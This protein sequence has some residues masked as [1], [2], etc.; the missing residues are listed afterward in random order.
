[1]SAP[2]RLGEWRPIATAPKDGSWFATWSPLDDGSE[3]N[4]DKAQWDE[5]EGCFLKVCC[6]WPYVTHWAPFLPGKP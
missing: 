1:M 2:P 4:L 6:G 5:Q 3:G